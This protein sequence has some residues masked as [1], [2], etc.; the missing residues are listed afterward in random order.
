V[1]LSE[2][3]SKPWTSV[4]ELNILG[5][6]EDVVIDDPRE[7]PDAIAQGEWKL[8]SVDSEE[9]LGEEARKA[10]DGDPKTIWHTEWR[11]RKPEH[12][13]ELSIDLGA[14]YSVE[15]FG[16]LP[17]QDSSM[18][19]TIKDYEF[20]V[21]QD[22]QT[23][24]TPAASGQFANSKNEQ[25]VSF[26]STAGRYVRL[27]ALSEGNSKPWTS[28]AELNILGTPAALR[29]PVMAR[30][31]EAAVIP[32]SGNNG[33]VA[34]INILS[35]P[36]NGKAA[37]DGENAIVYTP[38][39]DYA[40]AD[41]IH[42]EIVYADGSRE[43]TSVPVHV[44][45]AECASGVKLALSWDVNPSSEYVK[46][47]RVYRGADAGT[48]NQLVSDLSGTSAQYD[49]WNELGLKSGEQVCFRLKAYNSV[50]ESG[51]SEAACTT[52]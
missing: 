50:G 31:N 1:A 3:N 17:R 19:G 5:T 12:P 2:G 23:W 18:N 14:V 33:T 36:A 11:N 35:R 7:T 28:V 39:P 38:N 29:Q 6:P 25:H 13:H 15:G 9:P 40:G 48:A 52:M 46:G 32:V 16:Y 42:Y 41:A 51:F 49:A 21:S 47:Y 22:G 27:V 37:V 26:A 43:L 8:V 45:C 10:F 24:G 4:A 30:Q 34:S 44:E 20:Y